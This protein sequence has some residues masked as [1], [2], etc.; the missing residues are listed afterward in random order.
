MINFSKLR[1]IVSSCFKLHE[2][3]LKFRKIKYFKNQE[4]NLKVKYIYR[5]CRFFFNSKTRRRSVL[6]E[7]F[8]NIQN[9]S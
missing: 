1:K 7:A 8:N 9:T 2:I 5:I 4:P 6:Y 3:C